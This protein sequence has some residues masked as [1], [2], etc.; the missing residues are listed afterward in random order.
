MK[1]IVSTVTS[2]NIGIGLIGYPASGK[3]YSTSILKES[4]LDTIAIAIGDIVREIISKDPNY[5]DEPNGETI[6]EWVTSKLDENDEAVIREV[7]SELDTM[8]LDTITV[9]DGIRT[10]ADVRVLKDY[11]ETFV[12]IFLKVP[13]DIRLERINNRARDEDEANYSMEDLY[14]RDEDEESWGLKELVDGEVYDYSI[15]AYGDG[16]EQRI[17]GLVGE[18]E[19]T[20][21]NG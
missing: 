17:V 7:V 4:N 2:E 11:F 16:Y 12:L 10:Q 14:S 3:S 19:D 8:E 5:A 20:H 6:R 1:R 9:I 21:R 13:D 15:E 18:I